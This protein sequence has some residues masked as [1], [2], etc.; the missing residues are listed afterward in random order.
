MKRSACLL[1]VLAALF[2]AGCIGGPAA[3]NVKYEVTGTASIVSVTYYNRDGGIS[4][5]N[6]V[7]VPW[8]YSFDT[9]ESGKFVY[10]AAQNMTDSGAVTVTIYKNGAVFKTATSS[11]AYVIAMASGTL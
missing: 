1:V 2:L 10:V 9:T 4:Q 3:I 8:S 7:A 11:G 6:N 5:E